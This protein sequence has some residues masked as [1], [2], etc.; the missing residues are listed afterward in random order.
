MLGLALAA[1]AL[2]PAVSVA[3]IDVTVCRPGWAASVRPPAAV[4]RRFERR[5]LPAGADPRGFVVDHHIPISLGGAPADIANLRLQA[6]ATARAKDVDERRL[7][8][9]VCAGRM[10]LEDAQ[11]ELRRLWP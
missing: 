5:A 2:N 7:H 9:A 10:R 3:S 6:V 1:L 4:T 11:D 8:R